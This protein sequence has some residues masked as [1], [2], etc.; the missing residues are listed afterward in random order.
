MK[1]NFKITTECPACCKCCQE[2][3]NNYKKNSNRF[4]PDYRV[5]EKIIDLL[6]KCGDSVNSISITGGEPSI[7]TE[8]PEIV[9]M[10]TKEG[11]RVGIDTNGWNVTDVWLSKMEQAG[12][13][14][15]LI[16]FYSKNKETFDKLRGSENTLLFDRAFCALQSLKKLKENNSTINVRQQVILLKENYKEIPNLLRMALE[17]QFDAFSTA[18][19]ISATEDKTLTMNQ[20]DIDIFK[21]DVVHQIR[22]ILYDSKLDTKIIEENEKRLAEFFVFGNQSIDQIAHGLYRN[23]NSMCNEK[24]KIVIYPNGDVVP[25][26][27]YDYI[28]EQISEVNILDSNY[29][30]I[31]QSTLFSSFWTKQFALCERCSNGFQVWLNLK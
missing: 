22:Q 29:N 12:L 17:F 8:L 5:Y 21:T 9:K 16:S 20:E 18:Y 26:T 4:K 1:I 30:Q 24:N 10:F 3:L 14:Y 7:I 13:D 15:I 6:L 28:M 23:K 25:C 2:R 11:I 27:G 19:F 31:M